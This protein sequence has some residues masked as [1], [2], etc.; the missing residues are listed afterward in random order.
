MSPAEVTYSIP[1]PSTPDNALARIA[2]AS[3]AVEAAL[4]TR[5][6]PSE[7]IRLQLGLVRD[8]GSAY[9]LM[10]S[11]DDCATA[12]VMAG[13]MAVPAL[14]A[15][16]LSESPDPRLLDARDAAA[17]TECLGLN[18]LAM[19]RRIPPSEPRDRIVCPR[20]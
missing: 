12:V 1:T 5:A 9:G 17:I 14:D 11:D 7:L 2:I 13:R 19:L 4:T 6:A 15:D 3:A 20:P 16:L 10:W 18:V 8:L